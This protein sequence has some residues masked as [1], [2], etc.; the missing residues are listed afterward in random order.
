MQCRLDPSIDPSIE[1][2]SIRPRPAAGTY[3]RAQRV[4][5]V[6]AFG[7]S[8]SVWTKLARHPRDC[9]EYLQFCK[10]EKAIR[11]FVRAEGEAATARSGCPISDDRGLFLI[12]LRYF[13]PSPR[14]IFDAFFYSTR[15]CEYILVCVNVYA[16]RLPACTLRIRRFA[17][18][19]IRL[20]YRVFFG[21]FVSDK[22]DAINCY[23]RS[24]YTARTIP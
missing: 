11:V 17:L 21:E 24:L 16:L 14:V 6:S 8:T 13:L 23:T 1:H 5:L 19:P 7:S 20:L 3:A 12:P 22:R 9:Q 15:I 10:S 4:A 18:F 2:R